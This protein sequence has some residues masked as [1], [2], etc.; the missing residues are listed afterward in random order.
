[1]SGSG[2]DVLWQVSRLEMEGRRGDRPGAGGGVGPACAIP[3]TTSR[4]AVVSATF[5]S[6]PRAAHADPSITSARPYP[7]LS[8]PFSS[9][10]LLFFLPASYLLSLS[11]LPSP[12]LFFLRAFESCLSVHLIKLCICSPSLLCPCI[13]FLF[14][15]CHIFL[16]P[17][18]RSTLQS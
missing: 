8:L 5:T 4:T 15:I 9:P 10:P 6:A 17:V 12:R 3:A 11:S 2:A 14:R 13:A 18:L 16:S 1:M 7:L